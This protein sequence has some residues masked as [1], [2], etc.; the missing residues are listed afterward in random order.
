MVKVL[1]GYSV[2]I[3]AHLLFKTMILTIFLLR[4]DALALAHYNIMIV[5]VLIGLLN[6]RN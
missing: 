5:L 4:L 2:R 3:S 1:V 6:E